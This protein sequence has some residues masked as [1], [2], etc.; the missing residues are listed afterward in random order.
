MRERIVRVALV[1]SVVAV[2]ALGLPLAFAV[3]HL[4]LA[5]EQSE[6]ERVALRTAA[7]VTPASLTGDPVELPT[8]EKG[9]KLSVYDA[10]GRRADGRGPRR[11]SAPAVGVFQGSSVGV[12]TPGSL[13]EVVPV[14]S[15][16]R[17]IGAVRA[18]TSRVAANHR[19][20]SWWLA[21]AG[22]CV[23]ALVLAGIVALREGRRLARPLESLAASVDRL[24]DGQERPSTPP[25]GVVEIDAV[26]R[27]LDRSATELRAQILRERAFSGHASHQLRTPLT[28]LRLEL[29]R[30]L[31]GPE[32]ALREAATNAL[33]R[34]A[35]LSSTV[36]D[37]LS[38]ARSP[39]AETVIELDPLLEEQRRQWHGP[40]SEAGRPLRVS[41]GEAGGAP[42]VSPVASVDPAALRQVLQVLLDNAY[43]HGGGAVVVTV[44]ESYGALAIDVADSGQAPPIT[45][46][47]EDSMGLPLARDLCLSMGGRLLVDQGEG[48][49]FTVLLPGAP[50]DATAIGSTA[51]NRPER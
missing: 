13:V 15:G 8:T 35:A 48:T 30:A 45:L 36:D 4:V 10:A 33:A 43:R 28:R 16:E 26:S 22:G 37:V 49:R 23:A 20:W 1:S 14:S 42:G 5:D 47:G 40:L 21:L 12:S 29:E 9:V 2:V 17:V 19:T 41:T 6:L 27:A 31:G 3:R 25:S 18:A 34:A 46:A 50:D 11:L 32:N 38:M 7:A 39:Q 44:R 51:A 24:P